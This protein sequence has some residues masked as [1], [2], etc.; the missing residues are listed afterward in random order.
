MICDGKRRSSRRRSYTA[1]S[2]RISPGLPARPP[3]HHKLVEAMG[4]QRV[5][6]TLDIT[7]T[8][9]RRNDRGLWAIDECVRACGVDTRQ[10]PS[11]SPPGLQRSISAGN[12][13]YRNARHDAVSSPLISPTLSLLPLLSSSPLPSLLFP[14]TLFSSHLPTSPRPSL[15]LSFSCLLLSFAPRTLPTN[16]GCSAC[17]QNCRTPS[18]GP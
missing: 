7:T 2:T 4:R 6:M 9:K 5:K 1:R 14:S 18:T 13:Q 17:P 16:L 10:R 12:A 3:T 8:G 15:L 11:D